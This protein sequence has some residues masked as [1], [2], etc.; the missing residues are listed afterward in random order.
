MV[1]NQINPYKKEIVTKYRKSKA[2]QDSKKQFSSFQPP[3]ESVRDT[4]TDLYSMW[5][6]SY[7]AGGYAKET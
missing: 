2:F 1:K 7:G 5:S 6:K 3:W 4:A